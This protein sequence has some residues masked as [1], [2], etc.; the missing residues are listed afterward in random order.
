MNIL[1]FKEIIPDDY[2]IFKNCTDELYCN[3]ESSF[4]T[5]YMWQHYSNVKY[6]VK[7]NI[8]YSLFK[9]N[10]GKYES[11]MPYG[12]YANLPETIE[13][14]LKLY[15]TLQSSLTINLCTQ[16]FVDFLTCC[17]DKY[18]ISITENPNW[19][20]YVYYTD[21]LIN[22]SGKKY[23]SKRNHI[24]SF[25]KKYNYDYVKYNDSLKNE[26][27]EFCSNILNEHYGSSRKDYD[28]EFYSISKT[29]DNIDK[30]NLKC[31]L[32]MVDNKIVALSVGERL[33]KDYALIHIEKADYNYRTAYA[34]INNLFLKNEFHDTTYVNR[35]EDMGIE[36]L[37]VAKQSYNPCKMLK[38]YTVE[39]N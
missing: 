14:L 7:N 2:E 36:G 22:L 18:D 15:K 20:D 23:H 12:K 13:E 4:S 6:C 16:D 17:S 19:F 11:F 38:K 37:R 8:I 34:V 1:D 33:N 3:S 28:T 29:F 27:L 30:F 32:I 5:M 39:F 31:G 9:T 35:E 10:T 24:N 21:E 26:C 25:V